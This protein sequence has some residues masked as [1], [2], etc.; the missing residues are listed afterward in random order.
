MGANSASTPSIT[1]CLH[2]RQPM[3]A[4]RQPHCTHSFVFSFEYTRWSCHTGH[5]VGSPGS[6]RFTR[7]GSVGIVRIFFVTLSGA[8]RS[9][10]VLLYDF[11]IFW[12][13]RPGM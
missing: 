12:P 4:L 2:S 6:V 13:S 9:A 10:I 7:A 11:D 3:P 5:F 1:G 8:S